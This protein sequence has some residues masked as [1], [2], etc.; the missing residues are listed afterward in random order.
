MP[1][2]PRLPHRRRVI[3]KYNI[4][5]DAPAEAPF[6]H[7]PHWPIIRR[8]LVKDVQSLGQTQY[9]DYQESISVDAIHRPWRK[10]VRQRAKRIA[11]QAQ[12]CLAN[13]ENESEWRYK[14]ETEVMARMSIEVACRRCRGRLWRSEKEVNPGNQAGE[15]ARRL[16]ERQQEREPCT[17]DANDDW[18][19]KA[20]TGINPLF[21]Y[22]IEEGIVYPEELKAEL[23]RKR[24]EMPDRIYGMRATKRLE[25]ALNCLDKRPSA[26]GQCISDSITTHPFGGDAEPVHFPFLVLEAKSEKGAESLSRAADQTA[27]AI[28]ELLLIQ[29]GLRV[30]AG[31]DAEW[32]AGPLVWFLSFKG[33]EWKVCIAYVSVENGSQYFRVLQLWRGAVNVRDGALQLLLIIDYIF[34]WARDMYRE[35]VIRSLNRLAVSGSKT[36]SYQDSDIFSTCPRDRV[37]LWLEAT[38]EGDGTRGLGAQESTVIQDG[39]RCFDTRSGVIRDIRYIQSKFLGLYLTRNNLDAFFNS[40]NT[41]LESK[42]LARTLLTHLVEGWRVTGE[43]LDALE[44]NWTGKDRGQGQPFQDTT[45]LVVA[46]VAAY[47]SPD[48]QQTRELSYIAVEEHA[49]HD[50]L[51]HAGRKLADG[52]NVSDLPFVGRDD[53]SHILLVLHRQSAGSNLLACISRVCLST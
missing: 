39:L 25:R 19:D 52:Y 28:R 10:Q 31:E 42:R 44:F 11:A 3:K 45:F 41:E 32:D 16:R 26:S 51:K 36:V 5:F 29:E 27:F 8:V 22:H 7:P 43:T 34:D 48:W 37:R 47:L 6:Q 46:G 15:T 24:N 40:A 53:F 17:C 49:V 4:Q 38:N 18:D 33:E 21:D 14:V 30:A 50:L 13:R 2:N 9:Q 20:E 12:S 1:S 35:S 23:S